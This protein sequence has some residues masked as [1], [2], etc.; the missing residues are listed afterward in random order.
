MY[1]AVLYTFN[2]WGN[3]KNIEGLDNTCCGSNSENLTFQ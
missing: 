2:N 3:I 1:S